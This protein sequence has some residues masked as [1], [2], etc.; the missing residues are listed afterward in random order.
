MFG[1]YFMGHP[2]LR[3]LLNDYGFDGHPLRKDFPLGG[4]VELIY[5]AHMGAVRYVSPPIFR[6]EY[7]DYE[8]IETEWED[9]YHR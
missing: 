1:V 3:R 8:N 5:D 7:R 9:L 2:D 6:E 4:Y